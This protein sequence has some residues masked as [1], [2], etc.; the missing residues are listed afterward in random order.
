VWPLSIAPYTVVVVP[1][2]VQNP[3]VV[4]AAEGLTRAF[5]A[6]GLDVLLDDRDA[7]PGFKF[8]DADLIGIPLRVVVGERGLKEGTVEVKWRT[9]PEAHHVTVATAG[10][11]ILAEL[12]TTRKSLEAIRVE[13]RVARAA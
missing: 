11:A 7:R 3:A 9:N 8:K 1:L 2:Q 13:R 12:E 6:A 4:E 10:E 5:E